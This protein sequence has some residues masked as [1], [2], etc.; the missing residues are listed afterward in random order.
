MQLKSTI[1]RATASFLNKK[2]ALPAF[3][4]ETQKA[5]TKGLLFRSCWYAIIQHLL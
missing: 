4:T 1:L 3:D 5:A 2:A